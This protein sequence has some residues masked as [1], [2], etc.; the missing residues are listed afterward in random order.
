MMR[1]VAEGIGDADVVLVLKDATRFSPD[2][3]VV[4]PKQIPP[5]LLKD[6]PAILAINKVDILKQ[7]DDLL[8]QIE[9]YN[10]SG[11]FR[12]I[13]PI[14]AREKINTERLEQ[15]LLSYIP[16][17]E[18]FFPPDTLSDQQ[19]R[20]F[21]AEII[22]EKI[23]EM[24]REE[25]PY[26]TEV[27]IIEFKERGK[28]KWYVDAEINVERDTQKGIVIGAKGAM[29]KQ[30]GERARKDIERFLDHPVFLSLQVK[31]TK[32][33]RKNKSDLREFGYE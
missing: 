26:A 4:D 31:V 12:E 8:P 16:E 14:S 23:F 1:S 28:G 32:D 27:Q 11:Q 21:V 30:I 33:W 15:S 9:F 18:P 25:L 13:I 17:H 3:P 20:F 29:L 24:L 6:K 2:Q 19:E 22:R 7:K 5:A 10:K